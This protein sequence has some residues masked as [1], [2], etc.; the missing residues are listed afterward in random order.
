M[1]Q[2]TIIFNFESFEGAFSVH[3]EMF[4]RIRVNGYLTYAEL[5]YEIL[6]EPKPTNI[7]REYTIYGWQNLFGVSVDHARSEKGVYWYIK[8]PDMIV[9]NKN[10]LNIE[11]KNNNEQ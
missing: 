3:K 5:I 2:D 7:K 11:R 4:R 1:E 9:V 10:K 6:G 8:M